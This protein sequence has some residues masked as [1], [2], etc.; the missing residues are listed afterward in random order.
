MRSRIKHH[1]KVRGP[2]SP[3]GIAAIVAC[4]VGFGVVSYAPIPSPNAYGK[5]TQ[6]YTLQEIVDYTHVQREQ[7]LLKLPENASLL[8]RDVME[9]V[10]KDL[11]F[12]AETDSDGNIVPSKDREKIEM[13]ASRMTRFDDS[14]E[15][16]ARLQNFETNY[17]R[18]NFMQESAGNHLAMS[19]AGAVGLSQL[20]PYVAPQFDVPVN[21]YID[22]RRNPR[23]S[24]FGG[25]NYLA[26]RRAEHPDWPEWL[27]LAAYNCNPDKIAALVEEKQSTRWEDLKDF[28]PEETRGH[29]VKVLAI[30]YILDHE[31]DLGFAYERRPLFSEM[32]HKVVMHTVENGETVQCIARK[33]G[34]S[35][36]DIKKLHPE[37]KG[38][39]LPEGYNVS[40]PQM[41]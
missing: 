28:L 7:P 22:A 17:V 10:A 33:Y 41:V 8:E 26:R 36:T 11:A 12:E 6:P 14:I 18:A 4:A 37:I 3:R 20:M 35:P 15:E 19:R 27:Y 34:V 9:Q 25:V 29:V 2:I 38:N 5:D 40:V 32:Y 30:K 24:I 1:N 16:E 13:A 31:G 23:M 39:K 21:S